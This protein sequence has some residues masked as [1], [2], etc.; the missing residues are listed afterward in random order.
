MTGFAD[1]SSRW[2]AVRVK[3]NREKVVATALE[4]RGYEQ[5]LPLYRTRR[6]WSDRLKDVDLPLFSGYCFCRLDPRYRLPVLTIPGVFSFVGVGGIPTPL[7][8]EEVAALQAVA[9]SGS[10]A[11][12]WPFLEAGQRVR[13]ERGAFK[14][15][16]GFLISVKNRFRLVL[17]ISL[18]Q[19]SVAVEVD[20]DSVIPI[21]FR[22]AVASAGI[23]LSR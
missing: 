15:V 14:D 2:F 12:P 13:I 21:S 4:L 16:E 22:P 23:L 8:D 18:L 5:F 19:R 7:E 10:P 9:R 6:Q 3:S 17:S 20:R 1:T 11:A